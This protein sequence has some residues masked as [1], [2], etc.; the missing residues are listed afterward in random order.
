MGSTLHRK[1]NGVSII[2]ILIYYA[3]GSVHKLNEFKHFGAKIFS[4]KQYNF[5]RISFLQVAHILTK[6]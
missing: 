5:R 2:F 4:C 1:R 6:C 3:V